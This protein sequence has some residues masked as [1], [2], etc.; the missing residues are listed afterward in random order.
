MTSPYRGT[1]EAVESEPL[2]AFRRVER[3]GLWYA[4]KVARGSAELEARAAR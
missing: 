1:S 2:P 3:D 4:R